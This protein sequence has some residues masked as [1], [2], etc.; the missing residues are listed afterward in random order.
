MPRSG[1][2]W[3]VNSG[4]DRLAGSVLEVIQV[5]GHLLHMSAPDK[6][7]QVLAKLLGC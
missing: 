5:R 7:I 3:K 1:N 4:H 2:R 6:V